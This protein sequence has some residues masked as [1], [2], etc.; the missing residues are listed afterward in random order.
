MQAQRGLLMREPLHFRLVE[1]REGPV[2][3]YLVRS[4]CQP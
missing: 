4:C 2:C 1:N 3:S